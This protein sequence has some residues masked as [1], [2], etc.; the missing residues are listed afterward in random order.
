LRP[1]PPA[2]APRPPGRRD[3]AAAGWRRGPGGPAPRGGARGADGDGGGRGCGLADATGGEH[4]RQRDDEGCLAEHGD[5]PRV[6]AVLAVVGQQE[7]AEARPSAL[8]GIGEKDAELL[9]Q[10]LGI[11]TIRDMANSK[12]FKWAR[13]IV[14]AADLEE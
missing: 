3:R 6:Q 1:A 10:A 5:P 9:A 14:I 7:L 2:A 11:K 8:A 13:A 4:E 12:F